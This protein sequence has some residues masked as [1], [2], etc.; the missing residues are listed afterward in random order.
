MR[1]TPKHHDWISVQHRYMATQK[2]GGDSRE[3]SLCQ[4]NMSTILQSFW[5]FLSKFFAMMALV[6]QML[7]QPIS[8]LASNINFKPKIFN[9]SI[10]REVKRGNFETWNLNIKSYTLTDGGYDLLLLP[11][12][13]KASI[14]SGNLKYERIKPNQFQIVAQRLKSPIFRMIFNSIFR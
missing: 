5:D 3:L 8:E 10:F 9:N 4:W 11:K 2:N 14:R 12:S 7:N 6:S 13:D 1:G